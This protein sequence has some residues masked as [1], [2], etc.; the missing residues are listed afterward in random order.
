MAIEH[1]QLYKS[2]PTLEAMKR[3]YVEGSHPAVVEFGSAATILAGTVMGY[4]TANDTWTPWTDGAV[5]GSQVVKGILWPED[6]VMNGTDDKVAN[7]LV[8]GR[9]HFNDLVAHTFVQGVDT[10]EYAAL[11]VNLETESRPAGIYVEGAENWR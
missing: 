8:K 3:V 6:A 4:I 1:E 10:A 5:D 2:G 9:V 11:K 7:I